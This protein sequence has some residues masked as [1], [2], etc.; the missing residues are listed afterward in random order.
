MNR[1]TTS[2]NDTAT[3]SSFAMYENCPCI[4]FEKRSAFFQHLCDMA[5]FRQAS[6]LVKKLDVLVIDTILFELICGVAKCW[7]ALLMTKIAADHE[8]HIAILQKITERIHLRWKLCV[9]RYTKM[10]ILFANRFHRRCAVI[11]TNNLYSRKAHHR[12]LAVILACRLCYNRSGN[13]AAL[14]ALGGCCAVAHRVFL[15]VEGITIFVCSFHMA[16]VARGSQCRQNWR[17]A[18]DMTERLLVDL[19]SFRRAQKTKC[20]W[21]GIVNCCDRVS[22]NQKLTWNKPRCVKC[23]N[24]F[25]KL[26]ACK[27]CEDIIIQA[28]C[29][30]PA[31]FYCDLQSFPTSLDWHHLLAIILP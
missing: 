29:V 31:M 4:C 25:P 14:Q 26:A 10:L 6:A 21:V 11:N 24:H 28:I 19:R 17:K 12:G 30:D 1:Q 23:G 8:L 7:H 9:I 2:K 15:V 18:G 22:T 3:K 5:T 20:L 27:I 16:Q 13:I